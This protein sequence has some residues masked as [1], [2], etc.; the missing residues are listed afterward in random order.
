MG[1]EPW[2]PSVSPTLLLP[3]AADDGAIEEATL[4]VGLRAAAAVLPPPLS[5]LVPL[6]VVLSRA[7]REALPGTVAPPTTCALEANK[8]TFVVAA[9][10]AAAVATMRPVAVSSRAPSRSASNVANAW[11]AEVEAAAATEEAVEAEVGER[12]VEAGDVMSLPPS[13]PPVAADHRGGKEGN[14]R[15]TRWWSSAPP[16]SKSRPQSRSAH[17]SSPTTSPDGTSTAHV[18]GCS[19]YTAAHRGCCV[20]MAGV[21]RRLLLEPGEAGGAPVSPAPLS[22]VPRSHTSTP[23]SCRCRCTFV[24]THASSEALRSSAAAAAAAAEAASEAAS[25]CAPLGVEGAFEERWKRK[26][27]CGATVRRGGV[28]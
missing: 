3:L 13:G 14:Q 7:S 17:Q 1:T 20:K 18:E 22:E 5:P 16:L 23:S 28:L 12:G 4:L 27:V 15:S 24:P 11:R 6:P 21:M 25:L 2:L 10:H 9:R 8:P 19:S 26:G